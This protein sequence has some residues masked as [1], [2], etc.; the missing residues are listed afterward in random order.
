LFI[1]LKALTHLSPNLVS[2]AEPHW[3]GADPNEWAWRTVVRQHD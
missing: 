1:Y 2:C 3:I